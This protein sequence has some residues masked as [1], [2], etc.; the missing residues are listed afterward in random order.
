YM[1][2]LSACVGIVMALVL[3][4]IQHWGF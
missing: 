1:L 3:L 2:T 4:R